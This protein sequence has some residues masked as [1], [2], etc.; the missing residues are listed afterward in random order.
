MA[1]W[2]VPPTDKDG[3]V[4]F[5]DPAANRIYKADPDG[6]VTLFKDHTMGAKAMSESGPDGLLYASQ[7][8]LKRIVAYGSGGDEK[9]IAQNV[10][11]ERHRHHCAGFTLYFTDAIHKTVGYVDAKRRSACR[12]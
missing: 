7:P 5:A 4:F 12:L 8:A 1:P 10:E 9:V 11:A 6:K 3:N 2:Q